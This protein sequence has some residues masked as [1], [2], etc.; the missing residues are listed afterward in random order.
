VAAG[1]PRGFIIGGGAA[2]QATLRPGAR[3]RLSVG[4]GPRSVMEVLERR[5]AGAL[6]SA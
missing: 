6:A 2:C 3:R 4:G 1:R 5:A